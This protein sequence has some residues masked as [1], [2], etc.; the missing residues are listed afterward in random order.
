VRFYHDQLGFRVVGGENYG[1]E[2]ERLSGVS[3]AR[4]RI[5]S[6]RA[7]R[8]PGVELLQYE[9]PTNGRPFPADSSQT[10]LVHHEIIM[11]AP[12]TAR[13]VMTADPD[14]HPVELKP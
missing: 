14:G 4:V 3:G 13:P 11:K 5:T 12:S 1:I 10:D 7:R 6:L 2:Q 8:G 9:S